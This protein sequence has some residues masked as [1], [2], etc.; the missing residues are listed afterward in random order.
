MK[1]INDKIVTLNKIAFMNNQ[2]PIENK[3]DS[4]LPGSLIKGLR[5]SGKEA[6]QYS[7]TMCNAISFYNV[8]FSQDMIDMEFSA[9][10]AYGVKTG[11]IGKNGFFNWEKLDVLNIFHVKAKEIKYVD[12]NTAPDDTI[13]QMCIQNKHGY[14]FMVAYK[15]GGVLYLSDTNFR[16]TGVTWDALADGDKVL[17]L[18]E[19]RAC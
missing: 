19:Y 11:A 5:C 15:T 13:F 10:I 8:L 12:F 17:W 14:H 9:F 2:F 7:A 3:V 16:G 18:K 1:E 4:L 6:L